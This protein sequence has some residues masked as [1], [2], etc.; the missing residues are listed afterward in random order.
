MFYLCLSFFRKRPWS[1]QL[2]HRGDEEVAEHDPTNPLCPGAKRGNGEIN[3]VYTKTFSFDNDFPAL[4]EEY[5][6]NHPFLEE[7]T[8]DIMEKSESPFFKMRVAKGKCRVM[9]FHP[10][11]NVSLPL[12]SEP[13][14]VAVVNQWINEYKQL[15]SKYSWVQIFENKGAIMGCSN[16]HPHCQIWASDYIPNEAHTEDKNQLAYYQSTG[17]RQLLIDYVEKELAL[18]ERI[19]E[20]NNDWV[21]LVPFWAFWPFETMLLPRRSIQRISQ[22]T[23]T[24]KESLAAIM[25]RLLIRYDNLFETSFPYSMGWH[26][27]S[28]SFKSVFVI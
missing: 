4:Q 16:P 2:E 15:G 20:V 11:S 7:K 14:I 23:E 25:K 6:T 9:C 24:D 26:G 27:M 17:G 8:R 1:G 10:K 12:M 19:V 5:K 28:N 18:G 22:L 13:E 3:P 21:V